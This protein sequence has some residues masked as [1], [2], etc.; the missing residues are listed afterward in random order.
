MELK[1]IFIG[2]I[3]PTITFH[4]STHITVILMEF[5]SSMGHG[6]SIANKLC[7]EYGSEKAKYS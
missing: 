3:I 1:Y 4:T 6:K 2:M 5:L 7:L